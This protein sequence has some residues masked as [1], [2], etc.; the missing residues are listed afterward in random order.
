MRMARVSPPLA[1]AAQCFPCDLPHVS[2]LPQTIFFNPSFL[3]RPFLI[4]RLLLLIKFITYFL[5]AYWDPNKGLQIM[6]CKKELHGT[7]G[8]TFV[9]VG[10]SILLDLATHDMDV[11]S[12]CVLAPNC[13]RHMRNSAM[14]NVT[15]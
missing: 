13:F 3:I 6:T 8:K 5:G 11:D 4:R 14:Y 2:V 7:A 12:P 1:I 9:H 10:S 15:G